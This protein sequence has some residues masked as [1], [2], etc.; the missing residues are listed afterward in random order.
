[1]QW[2]VLQT[3]PSREKDVSL[4][5]SQGG[6]EVF[7]PKIRET[8]YRSTT[9]YLKPV[10]LFPN[11]LF[12]HTS[13]DEAKNFHLVKYTRGVNKIVCAD[14]LP[15]PLAEEMIAVMKERTAESGFIERPVSL[16]AGDSIRVK[17]GMLKDLIGIL[18]RPASAEG[19]IHVLLNLLNYSMKATLHWTEVEKLKIA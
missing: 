13:F 11:Y 1:M 10:P 8:F 2:Y 12:I 9:S 6:F 15:I 18:E 16:K 4:L 5:L 19:R 7:L 3:K 17:K 14:G